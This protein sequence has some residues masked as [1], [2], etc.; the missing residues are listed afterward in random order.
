MSVAT[1]AWLTAAGVRQPSEAR[2]GI[3]GIAMM[4]AWFL[5][6]AIFAMLDTEVFQNE[7]VDEWV[8]AATPMGMTMLKSE[9]VPPAAVI[10]IQLAGVALVL[11]WSARRIARP[12]KVVA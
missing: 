7:H 5:A 4:F 1:L 3:A 9:F 12:G 8:A 2:A 6:V 10:A 11:W